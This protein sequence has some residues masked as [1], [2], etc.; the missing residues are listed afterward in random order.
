VKSL[1]DIL[2]K[3]C[4]CICGSKGHDQGYKKAIAGAYGCFP[5]I[6]VSYPNKAISIA[7]I[8]FGDIFHFGQSGQHFSDQWQRVSVLY[9][10]LVEFSVVNAWS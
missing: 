2:F 1:V 5:D 10:S 4:R 8:N 9:D 3:C 6:L 7:N